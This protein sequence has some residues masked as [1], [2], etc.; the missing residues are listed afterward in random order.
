MLFCCC[1]LVVFI[2]VDNCI[3]CNLTGCFQFELYC[4]SSYVCGFTGASTSITLCAPVLFRVEQQCR[5]H[6]KEDPPPPSNEGTFRGM[7]S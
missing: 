2:D 3:S 5:N 6:V 4:T 1:L 7:I